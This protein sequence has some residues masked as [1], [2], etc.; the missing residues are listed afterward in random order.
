MGYGIRDPDKNLFR[1]PDPGVIMA[2]DPRSGSATLAVKSTA[3]LPVSTGTVRYLQDGYIINGTQFGVREKVAK[4]LR[5]PLGRGSEF[6]ESET[7]V[8]C[9]I[10]TSPRV[11]FSKKTT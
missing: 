7:F 9:Q 10:R 6:I 3:Y 8:I 2:K 1:I 4:L 5:T 11:P